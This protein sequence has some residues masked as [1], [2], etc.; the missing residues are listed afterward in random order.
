[1]S[2]LKQIAL[3]VVTGRRM[4]GL[5]RPLMRHRCV[6]FMLHRFRAPELGVSEGHDPAGLRRSLEVLRKRKY[7]LVSVGQIF[8]L[9]AAGEPLPSWSVA[10]TLD[11]GYLEQAQVAGPVFAAYDC[12]ATVFVAT[13]F[14][15]GRI[16]FW[17][18]QV[19]YLFSHTSRAEL[20]VELDGVTS[21]VSWSDMDGRSRAEAEFVA[22]C[23]VVP[24]EAK[25]AAIAALSIAAE[26]DLPARPP[27]GYRPMSW[28]D[29][30]A[31]EQRGMTF[32]PHTVTH[33]ILSR[34][35]DAA[36][37][38]EIEESWRRLAAEATRT[39]K[40]FCYPNGGWED[41]GRRE[42]A[43]LERLG[44]LGG[45]VGEP[46]FADGHTAAGV[47]GLFGVPR[48]PYPDDLAHVV[49]YAAGIERL[50]M[51]ARRAVP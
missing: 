40:V 37:T 32:G 31:A 26:V 46:G 14:L 28:E 43:T 42:V 50:K 35:G 25:H 44:F 51:I 17:W 11:D 49:Q 16:W 1:M 29:L 3:H 23:K 6:I 48:F 34:T 9:L 18:D 8:D 27:E 12:P 19:K 20:R 7:N 45:V 2:T 13:G 24:D 21:H 36:S 10:F 30:R 33:P 41:F 4:S 15:D 5:F 39:V 38:R 47:R 22:R